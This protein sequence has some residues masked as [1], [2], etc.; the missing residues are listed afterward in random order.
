[1]P[2][3]LENRFLNGIKSAFDRHFKKKSPVMTNTQFV[4][5]RAAVKKKT[6]GDQGSATV[7]D[8]VGQQRFCDLAGWKKRHLSFCRH[9]VAVG[10]DRL[11]CSVTA[12]C[13]II[14]GEGIVKFFNCVRIKNIVTVVENKIF[15][16]GNIGN[17]IFSRGIPPF[18]LRKYWTCGYFS[19]IISAVP[20]VEPSSTTIISQLGYVW[21]RSESRQKGR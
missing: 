14:G 13:F 1:M 12:C 4:I 11:V 2:S 15:S 16:F 10:I 21:F 19:F 7:D 18:S 17:I 5:I 8:D 9:F 3:S 20:S 6:G